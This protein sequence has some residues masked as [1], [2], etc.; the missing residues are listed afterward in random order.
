MVPQTNENIFD[1]EVL[2][3]F[4][5]YFIC[6][7]F[8]SESFARTYNIQYY[9]R[10]NIIHRILCMG[11]LNSYTTIITVIMMSFG[12]YTTAAV[13]PARI[14]IYCVLPLRRRQRYKS[15]KKKKKKKKAVER[16]RRPQRLDV[17][18][19]VVYAN[20]FFIYINIFFLPVHKNVRGFFFFYSILYSTPEQILRSPEHSNAKRRVV[21][22]NQINK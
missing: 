15:V 2:F 21:Y 1:A 8:F 7:F 12:S 9:I 10:N 22:T 14:I 18:V 19:V 13:Y 6:F 4:I 11:K 3:F 16:T 5:F 17:V 20:I